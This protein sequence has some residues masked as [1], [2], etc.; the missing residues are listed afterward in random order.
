MSRLGQILQKQLEA[1]EE[2]VRISQEYSGRSERLS[3]DE[4]ESLLRRRSEQVRHVEGLELERQ[5]LGQGE[6]EADANVLR[7]Q[8]ELQ[9][10][11][12][13]LAVVDD[14]LKD[15]VF[16]AKLQLTNT[17]AFSPTFVNLGR[18]ATEHHH[19]QRRVVDIMR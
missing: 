3:V 8:R 16:R 11:L 7:L 18:N 13:I 5:E 9:D 14:Y 19:P 12:S 1:V 2:I 15:L 6:R 10:A 4:L 17:L